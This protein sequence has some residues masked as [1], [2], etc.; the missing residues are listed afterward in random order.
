MKESSFNSCKS[1]QKCDETSL[2]GREMQ[3]S[4]FEPYLIPCLQ[5]FRIHI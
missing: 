2:L 1:T 3:E 4:L 5:P